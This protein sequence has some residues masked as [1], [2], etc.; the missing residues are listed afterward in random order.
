MFRANNLLNVSVDGKIYTAKKFSRQ[1]ANRQGEKDLKEQ[2]K[3]EKQKKPHP[4]KKPSIQPEPKSN[5][6]SHIQNSF[7]WAYPCARYESAQVPNAC[8]HFEIGDKK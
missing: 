6:Q 8:W 4:E 2:Q 7:V 5:T 3:K 1:C